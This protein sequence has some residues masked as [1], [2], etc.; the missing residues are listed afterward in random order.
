M[1]ALIKE[2]TEFIVAANGGRLGTYVAV[3]DHHL[4]SLSG[5]ADY[6]VAFLGN[7]KELTVRWS[8]ENDGPIFAMAADS[9]S[10]GVAIT[11]NETKLSKSDLGALVD[12]AENAYRDWV[13]E[14]TDTYDPC[15]EKS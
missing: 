2:A 6:V 10:R 12:L 9:E 1:N 11:R 15:E 7:G 8:G 4:E 5:E 13:A 14:D 3:V